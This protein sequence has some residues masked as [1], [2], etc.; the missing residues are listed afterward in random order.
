MI[1]VITKSILK[2]K[3]KNGFT[4]HDI[5]IQIDKILVS[6]NEFQFTTN[7]DIMS[8]S[9]LKTAAQNI[10]NNDEVVLT[11]AQV[12]AKVVDMMPSLIPE[13]RQ[14][15]RDTPI[16][17][18]LPNHIKLCLFHIALLDNPNEITVHHHTLREF[19]QDEILKI[20]QEE[21][22]LKFVVGNGSGPVQIEGIETL[23]DPQ[24][25]SLLSD[26][27]AEG[28]GPCPIPR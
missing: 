19:V 26:F 2:L 16:T 17:S 4:C 18:L 7:R 20:P 28:E 15:I 14:T 1:V 5:S 10:L 24:K 3:I 23:D 13:Q 22:P 21:I 9:E 11:L 6:Q 25:A 27:F 12:F 8:I